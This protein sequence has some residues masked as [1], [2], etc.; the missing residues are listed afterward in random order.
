LT[1]FPFHPGH[2]TE[3][4][5]VIEIYC[6]HGTWMFDDPAVGLQKEPFVGAVN[7]MLDLLVADIPNAAN[8][9]R[10]RFS[11][12]PF[13]GWK[14]ALEWVRNDPMEGDW[15]RLGEEEG[16]LCPSLLCYFPSAPKQI[17][18]AAEAKAG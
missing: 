3:G 9:V 5:Q 18:A 10:L 7:Q 2:D 14:I 13:P 12:T 8:G 17:Y 1:L 16:W 4:F 11:P 6:E 15:Y